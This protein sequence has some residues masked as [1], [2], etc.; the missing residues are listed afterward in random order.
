ME[1]WK[2]FILWVTYLVLA[3]V[4]GIWVLNTLFGL[5]L[6]YDVKNWTAFSLGL[7]LINPAGVLGIFNKHKS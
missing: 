6:A 4:A 5:G 7:F 2:L 1:I 3:G